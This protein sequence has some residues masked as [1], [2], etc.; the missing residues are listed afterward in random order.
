M[1]NSQVNQPMLLP[2]TN[3]EAKD[4]MTLAKAIKA[5]KRRA[6]DLADCRT[7]LKKVYGDATIEVIEVS[8][9][10]PI[11]KLDQTRLGELDPA[12]VLGIADDIQERHELEG[13]PQEDCLYKMPLVER[14][15]TPGNYS[16]RRVVGIHRLESYVLNQWDKVRCRVVE[17]DY[18]RTNNLSK[19]LFQL[20]SS[21]RGLQDGHTLREIENGL[22]KDWDEA[23][24]L[25]KKENALKWL[26]SSKQGYSDDD[27]QKMVKRIKKVKDKANATQTQQTQ[28]KQ[29]LVRT[30]YADTAKDAKLDPKRNQSHWVEANKKSLPAG[31]IFR[32]NA[33]TPGNFKKMIGDLVEKCHQSGEKRPY[34]AIREKNNIL[35]HVKPKTLSKTDSDNVSTM[36]DKHLT[37][38][39]AVIESQDLP[40]D[41]I[42]RYPQLVGEDKD[43]TKPIL[44]WSKAAGRVTKK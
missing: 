27:Y 13:V 40:W 9:I 7:L 26:H 17:E 14:V 32:F 18:F 12:K 35:F 21:P 4:R 37:D 23:P 5:A 39:I 25:G 28:E 33:S 3:T 38:F 30:Y 44:L 22:L 34:E 15:G 19:R 42:Y 1:T 43:M 31:R 11:T 16:Y 41:A 29:T 8:T 20:A 10:L 24:I 2:K 6:P 36:I